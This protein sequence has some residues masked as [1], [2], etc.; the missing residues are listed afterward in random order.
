MDD[1][2]NTVRIGY[3]AQLD[4]FLWYVMLFGNLT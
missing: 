3:T 4:N 2:A 1:F